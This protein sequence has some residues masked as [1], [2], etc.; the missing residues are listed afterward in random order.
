MFRNGVY[1]G[2]L[3]AV[4]LGIYLLQ[5]WAPERQVELHSLNL[6]AA[7]EDADADELTEFLADGYADDW[8][9]D[10]ALAVS[11]IRQ[12]VRYTRDLRLVPANASPRVVGLD[13]EW[14][15]RVTIEAEPTE[16]SVMMMER[17]NNLTEPFVLKW[18]RQSW[19][20]WDWKLVRA[21]N[22]RLELPRDVF[23]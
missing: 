3:A 21:S 12:I 2:L 17:V 1:A 7:I 18:R 22:P 23:P 13:G 20:P 6:L 11:R 8:G 9:H 16:L 14:H 5:L 4:A 15:A 19:K 10:K